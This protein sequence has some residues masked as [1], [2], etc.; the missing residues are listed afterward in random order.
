MVFDVA[1]VPPGGCIG[2]PAPL[3]HGGIPGTADSLRAKGK[4]K[5][6][7]GA[8]IIVYNYSNFVNLLLITRIISLAVFSRLLR[9]RV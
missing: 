5:Y 1:G 3:G 7:T 8:M 6:A 4:K 9:F 2:R